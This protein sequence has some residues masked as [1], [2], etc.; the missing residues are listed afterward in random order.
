MGV[1]WVEIPATSTQALNVHSCSGIT[2]LG[3]EE[4]VP[5]A[6]ATVRNFSDIPSCAFPN[7]NYKS[8]PSV[9]EFQVSGMTACH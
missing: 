3:G 2:G 7:K 4:E 6:V 1:P 8:R 9:T 5:T